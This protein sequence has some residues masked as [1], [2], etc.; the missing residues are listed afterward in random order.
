M[1][2]NLIESEPN[3]IDIGVGS[4]IRVRRRFLKMSQS[5]LAAQ[6]GLTFQQIQKYET[7]SNRVSASVLYKISQA[8]KMPVSYF[9]ESYLQEAEDQP[10][11]NT[12]EK[13]ITEFLALSEGYELL[14]SFPKI[15]SRKLRRM[16]VDFAK[17]ISESE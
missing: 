10:A 9:F 6:L 11:D 3:P 16:I 7:A 13:D 12:D 5:D 14:R 2:L 4:K 1:S 17:E 8:L 15:K